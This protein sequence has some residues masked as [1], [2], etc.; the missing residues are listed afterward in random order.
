MTKSWLVAGDFNDI[1]S[2]DEKK[3]RGPAQLRKCRIFNDRIHSCKLID[4]GATGPKFTWKGPQFNG[5]QRVYERLDRALCND[6]WRLQFESAGVKN[7][8]RVNFSD[9]HPILITLHEESN[10][11]YI[12]PFRFECAWLLHSNFKENLKASWKSEESLSSNIS[13]LKE[14]LGSWR[15]EIFGSIQANKRKLLA[16]ICGIQRK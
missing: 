9:H 5:L 13:K 6:Y 16:R 11:E 4:L 2:Q 12:R 8:P 1:K 15:K 10:R 14:S 7:L 3:G